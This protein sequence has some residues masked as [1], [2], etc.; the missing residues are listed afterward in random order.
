MET[1]IKAL[2]EQMAQ[3]EKELKAEQ[4]KCTKLI[5]QNTEL[6]KELE[7]SVVVDTVK[8]VEPIDKGKFFGNIFKA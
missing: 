5:S 1:R 6:R 8:K 4:D 7:T 3:Y 2:E